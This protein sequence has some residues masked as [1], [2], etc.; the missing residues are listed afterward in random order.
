M[1]LPMTISFSK[2]QYATI[3]KKV[4]TETL[5]FKIDIRGVAGVALFESRGSEKSGFCFR[6]WEGRYQLTCRSS[7][8]L[9]FFEFKNYE[10][11]TTQ[12]QELSRAFVVCKHH[13][14]HDS[15]ETCPLEFFSDSRTEICAICQESENIMKMEQTTCKHLFHLSCL[16]KWAT[17]EYEKAENADEGETF[18][19]CPICRTELLSDD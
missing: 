17:A 2:A 19:K 3:M 15:D 16:N 7:A 11:F 5:T 12:F 4:K 8:Q 14:Y 9:I 13:T 6:A 1:S 10:E 18:Y